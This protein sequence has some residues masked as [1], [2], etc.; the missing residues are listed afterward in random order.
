MKNLF[1]LKSSFFIYFFKCSLNGKT[2]IQCAS[3][4]SSS[5]FP[6]ISVFLMLGKWY[7][8][9]SNNAKYKLCV[10]ILWK[11]FPLSSLCLSFFKLNSLQSVPFLSLSL[12]PYILERYTR[13][14]NDITEYA[15]LFL[16][17]S[18]VLPNLLPRVIIF[19]YTIWNSKSNQ[20]YLFIFFWSAY[21]EMLYFS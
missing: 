6:F 17:T 2:L 3:G 16:Y 11:F 9:R 1:S 4:K 10:C 15:S 20:L 19:C 12:S 21:G 14:M 5:F 18:R 8:N 7:E 13:M